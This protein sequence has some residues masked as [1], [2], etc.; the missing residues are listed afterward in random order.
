[1]QNDISNLRVLELLRFTKSHQRHTE[2]LARA[3]A[4]HFNVFNILGIGHYEVKTHSPMLGELLNPKGCHSQGCL[5]LRLFL[6][7]FSES[8]GKD[9][10]FAQKIRDFNADDTA[11]LEMEVY[12]GQIDPG[13]TKGGK[14]DIVL[15][16]KK[17][18]HI[19]VENK[20]YAVDQENQMLRYHRHDP[21]AALLYLTLD[22][23]P[24]SPTSLGE[25][26]F[27][28]YSISYQEH[29]LR[30]LEKCRKEA[31]TLPIVRE[32]IT[33][34]IRLIEK[35]TNQ[36]TTLAMN[37]ELINEIL[38]DKENLAAFFKLRDAQIAVQTELIYRLD[39]QLD[40]IAETLELNREGQLQ[41]LN[42]K[43]NGFYFSTPGLDKCNL[44]IGFAFD[45]AG[46]QDFFFGFWHKQPRRNEDIPAAGKL[47]SEFKEKFSNLDKPNDYWP[48]SAWWDGQHYT[49]SDEFFE[50]IRS[51]KFADELKLKLEELAKI[52][53]KVCP[54]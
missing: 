23:K 50:A 20:I 26:N 31:A 11:T 22:G 33:Q 19:F 1:M 9:A 10:S 39:K 43:D 13:Y 52:A 53:R 54:D 7:S 47:Y 28:V 37:K 12:I 42:Q 45:K 5:F 2:A 15:T 18:N 8:T 4:E 36:S 25:A 16:D 40:E 49:S 27:S 32:T 35:L 17:K 44:Q 30:W 29:I 3:T 51:G 34:Y 41:S 14:I 38:N 48:A 21:N 46:Y 6:S 24:P